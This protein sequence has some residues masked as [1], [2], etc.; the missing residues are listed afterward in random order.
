MLEHTAPATPLPQLLERLHSDGY[1]ILPALLPPAQLQ[2]IHT[3][4]APWLQ[5][6][7]PGRNDFEGFQSERVYALLAKSPVFA[8]L[9]AHPLVL[10][11]CEAVLGPNFMLSACLA[12]NTH[13]GE[14][15]QPLHFDDS[16]YQVPRPR[17]A[18]GVSCFWAIDA[19]TADNGPTEIIPGSHRWDDTPPLGAAVEQSFKPGPALA[20]EHH[21]DLQQAV[22][23]AGSLML[24][25][26]TLW[27]RGGANRSAA[28]RLVI[29]PQYCVAWARQMESMLL[30]V[31]PAVVAGYPP[32]VQQLLGYNIH[33]PFMGHANGVHPM[34]TLPA[35][36]ST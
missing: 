34:R 5:G 26:G 10:A 30:S 6:R 13:P 22:M 35:K 28:P 33:P 23:P 11:V 21:P 12:I 15:E 25:M 29:T 19:F 3:A 32:R 7:L 18:Y 8:E 9:A 31:P 20:H 27:H 14:T 4:L 24:A 36:E 17:P 16:F 2:A 1:V